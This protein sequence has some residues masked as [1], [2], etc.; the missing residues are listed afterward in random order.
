MMVNLPN[1]RLRVLLHVLSHVALFS[2]LHVALTL[3]QQGGVGEEWT[4]EIPF[5]SE[6]EIERERL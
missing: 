6:K 4:K 2:A 3:L 5:K 1:H